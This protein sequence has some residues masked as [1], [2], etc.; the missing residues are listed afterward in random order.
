MARTGRDGPTDRAWPAVAVLGLALVVATSRDLW[1]AVEAARYVASGA[2]G[3]VYEST[4]ALT[5]LPLYPILLAPVMMW[6]SRSRLAR[7]TMLARVVDLPE[8]V[9]PV[10]STN[11][12]GRRA[13]LLTWPGMPS[14]SSALIS[15]GISR[16][17]APTESRWK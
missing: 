16:K 7:S 15:W 14:A 12:R 10:T 13:R 1:V 6:S 17:A 8:P 11:P 9:G 3:F 2:L 5:A 4:P